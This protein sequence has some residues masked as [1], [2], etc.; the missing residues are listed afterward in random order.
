MKFHKNKKSNTINL[1]ENVEI[2]KSN[3]SNLN[4]EN[5]IN[6]EIKKNQKHQI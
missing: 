1:K 5:I 4:K 6:S 2:K 3:A